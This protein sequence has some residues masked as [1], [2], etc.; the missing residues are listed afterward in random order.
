MTLSIPVHAGDVITAS[1]TVNAARTKV[2][3]QL[4]DATS[5]VGY[6]REFVATSPDVTSAELV[7]ESPVFCSTN[8][9]GAIP[10][11]N[12]NSILLTKIAVISNGH[13]GTI[14][15]PSWVATPLRLEARKETQLGRS[16]AGA[17]PN[18]LTRAGNAFRI[19]WTAPPPASPGT[20]IAG[21]RG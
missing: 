9:C 1:V 20:Y 12:F 16:V 2:R 17:I 11:A 14:N 8:G 5:R 18:G 4:T 19:F 7:A 21:P 6:S 13:L 15:D 3:L 10:L